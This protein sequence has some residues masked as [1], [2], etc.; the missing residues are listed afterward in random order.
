[1]VQHFVPAERW[2]FW[3]QSRLRLQTSRRTT[4]DWFQ[5]LTSPRT[6]LRDFTMCHLIKYF[7]SREMTLERCLMDF[8]SC[9]KC[10]II[11]SNFPLNFNYRKTP[12]KR[13]LPINAPPPTTQ[14]P[15]WVFLFLLTFLAVS[16]AKMVRFSFRKKL[17]KGKNALFEAIKLANAH[18]RLLGVLR[19]LVKLNWTDDKSLQHY[20]Q[21]LKHPESF[22]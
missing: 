5:F 17:L 20:I 12:K 7:T 6:S 22:K 16:Q 19:Y 14:S 9:F 11:F 15:K 1:M 21:T 8:Y 4:L 2:Q 10:P 18:G 3:I 13:P